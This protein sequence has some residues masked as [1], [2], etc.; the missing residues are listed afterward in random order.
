MSYHKWSR[1][2]GLPSMGSGYVKFHGKDI[3][4]GIRFWNKEFCGCVLRLV[5]RKIS[6]L[7]LQ[8]P[9]F[10]DFTAPIRSVLVPSSSVDRSVGCSVGSFK[11]K[12]SSVIGR[13]RRMSEVWLGVVLTASVLCVV[14]VSDGVIIV[15]EGNISMV[16]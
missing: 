2:I 16:S 15:Y 10:Q 12:F 9:Q 7:K 11:S 13:M 14:R 8:R 4:I 6:Y 3:P 1:V 5:E